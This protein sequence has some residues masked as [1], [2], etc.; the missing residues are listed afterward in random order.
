[1]KCNCL[2]CQHGKFGCSDHDGYTPIIECNISDAVP[3]WSLATTINCKSHVPGKRIVAPWDSILSYT[4]NMLSDK[5]L[6]CKEGIDMNSRLSEF[7]I[8]P[9]RLAFD[10]ANT[11]AVTISEERY[12]KWQTLE[13]AVN[14]VFSLL[15]S[16]GERL[17]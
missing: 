4:A 15:A 3:T 16:N 14:T 1:M 8:S 11:Y 6:K 10:L 17:K 5:F 9:G 13:Q 7:P 2:N 12:S